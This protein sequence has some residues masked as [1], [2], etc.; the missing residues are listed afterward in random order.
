MGLQILHNPEGGR[1]VD[2]IFV[3]GLGGTSRLTWSKNKDLDLFWPLTFLP[4]EPDIC[5]GRIMT[6][7][8][9]AGFLK[10][11][12]RTSATVLDFA[13]DLLYD[14]KYAKDED[15]ED[16]EIGSVRPGVQSDQEE[17]KLR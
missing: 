15:M 12:T 3:H 1:N 13:K 8:Y 5:K 6:F 11:N 9:N 10:A 7:G 16:L 4:F 14:L 2:I 17:L